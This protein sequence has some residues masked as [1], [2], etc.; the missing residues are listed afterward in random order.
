MSS[1]PSSESR[2]QNGDFRFRPFQRLRGQRAFARARNLGVYRHSAAA[3]VRILP[4]WELDA[5]LHTAAEP[6]DSAAEA[7]RALATG[8]RLGVVASRKVGNAVVRNR[9][10][11]L[12]REIFRLNQHRLPPQC[13]VLVIVR[14]GFSQAERAELEALFADVARRAHRAFGTGAE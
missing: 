9:A 3:L 8:R 4:P 7:K 1:E 6:I 2:A 5:P 11:R 12:W 14:K 10:K 13:D